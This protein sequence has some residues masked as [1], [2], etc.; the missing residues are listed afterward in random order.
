MGS[1][2]VDDESLQGAN[3]TRTT[4]RYLLPESSENRRYVWAGGALSTGKYGPYDVL[5]KDIRPVRE[6]FTL[7]A[8]GFELA[9]CPMPVS[10]APVM[11][12]CTL[13]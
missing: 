11:Q 10:S 3:D 2:K 7:E 13:T 8:K 1:I 6:R 9:T 12:G 5:I 4:V